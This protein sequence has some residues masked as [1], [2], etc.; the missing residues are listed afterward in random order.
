MADVARAGRGTDPNL[1]FKAG[2]R[3]LRFAIP[4]ITED[5]FTTGERQN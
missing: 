5:Y 4:A 2:E 3:A 1:F